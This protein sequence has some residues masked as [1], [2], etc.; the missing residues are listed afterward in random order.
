MF[1]LKLNNL[2]AIQTPKVAVVFMAIDVF[3]MEVAVFKIGLL[4]EAGFQ[5]IR[6][7]A[8][9]GGLGD[10]FFLV[11]QP[12]IELIYVEVIMCGK[13]LLDDGLTLRGISKPLFANKLSEYLY[14][15]FH[16]R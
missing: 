16:G 6:N 13:D 3:V 9:Y 1:L 2:S 11:F 10:L 12:Q 15:T 7:E 4:N 5:K 14:L 8:V